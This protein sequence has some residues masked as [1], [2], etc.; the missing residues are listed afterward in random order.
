[1]VTARDPRRIQDIV[2][3]HEGTGLA[4]KLD[5]T[6][7]VEV[8]EAVKKA[9]AVFGSIDVL[10]NNAGYGYLSAGEEGEDDEVRAM[11]EANFFGLTLIDPLA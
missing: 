6:N 3:G 5:V 9:E 7:E 11:F 8:A 1:M 2:A 10:V 4:L